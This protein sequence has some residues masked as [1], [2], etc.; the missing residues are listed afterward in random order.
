MYYNKLEKT[1]EKQH[2]DFLK[3]YDNLSNRYWLEFIKQPIGT[4]NSPVIELGDGITFLEQIYHPEPNSF[5]T[6]V[7][8]DI[9]TENEW[10][11]KMHLYEGELYSLKITKSYTDEEGKVV[12]AKIKVHYVTDESGEM[13]YEIEYKD[14]HSTI[15]FNDKRI[16]TVITMLSFVNTLFRCIE[17]YGKRLTKLSPIVGIMFEVKKSL[18]FYEKSL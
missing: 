17:V 7:K 1:M 5:I 2:F 9:N 16:R 15:L 8:F 4:D 10:E 18:D 3:E 12:T 11:Y 14:N 13:H 6:H